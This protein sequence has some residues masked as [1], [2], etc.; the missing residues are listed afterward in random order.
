M[1]IKIFALAVLGVI[2]PAQAWDL[3]T[4]EQPPANY[5]SKQIYGPCYDG[6]PYHFSVG[7]MEL[8]LPQITWLQGKHLGKN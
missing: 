7:Q 5:L 2:N 1:R 8:Y 6:F 3:F 4:K